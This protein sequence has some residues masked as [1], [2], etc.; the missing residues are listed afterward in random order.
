MAR[1]HAVS[2]LEAALR[3]IARELDRARVAW[4]LV[5]GLAVSARA[6]PRFTRDLDLVVAVPDDGEAEVLTRGLL[7]SGYRVLATLEQEAAGRLATVRLASPGEEAGGVVVDL[8]FASSG[9][10][11]EIAGRADAL[12][13]LPGLRVKVARAGDLLALKLLAVS[14][15]RPQDEADIVALLRDSTPGDIEDARAAAALIVERGFHRGRDL[16]RDLE[17]R[18]GSPLGQP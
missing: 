6:E 4:A 13:I 16:P 17:R 15:G 7:A 12:E 5:G 18:I 11:P 3:A 9:I 8:L 1:A 2:R 10:E 14:P